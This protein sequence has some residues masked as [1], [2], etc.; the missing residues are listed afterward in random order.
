VKVN[1]GTRNPA[2]LEAVSGVLDRL[3]EGV[4][5]TGVKVDSGVPD[6]PRGGE[7]VQGALN[8]ARAVLADADLGIGIEAGLFKVPGMEIVMDVQYCVVL[9]KHGGMTVGHGMGF[10]LPPKALALIE[11]GKELNDVMFEL[12]GEEDIGSRE[13]AIHYFSNGAMDR[14][15]LTEQAVLAAMVPRL[16]PDVYG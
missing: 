13:G 9:D 6:Q 8:R 14:A 7:A 11:Q 4:E 2:K 10:A 5:L 3:F 16:R 12:Y 1:V 15:K